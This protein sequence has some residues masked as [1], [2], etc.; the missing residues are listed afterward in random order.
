M[1]PLNVVVFFLCLVVGGACDSFCVSCVLCSVVVVV[2]G[3]SVNVW[4]VCRGFPPEPHPPPQTRSVGLLPP[5][6]GVNRVVVVVVHVCCVCVR[7][8]LL[9]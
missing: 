6:L 3:V 7:W 1:F 2:M 4:R 5:G 9:R 8:R